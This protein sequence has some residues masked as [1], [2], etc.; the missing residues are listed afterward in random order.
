MSDTEIISP[1]V[2]AWAPTGT[3][4]AR[5]QMVI[6]SLQVSPLPD[7]GR[8]LTITDRNGVRR[9]E[10]SRAAAQHLAG[11]LSGDVS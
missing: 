9:F 11:L 8:L 10:L 5:V 3:M 1:S 4:V 2:F 7:G 6:E